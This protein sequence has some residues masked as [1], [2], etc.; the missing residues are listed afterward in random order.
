MRGRTADVADEPGVGD[1][2]LG[3][4]G[5]SGVVGGCAGRLAPVEVGHDRVVAKLGE[6]SDDLLGAAVVAGHVVD[7][8]NPA[9][10]PVARRTYDVGLDL[11]AVV[12][13]DPD[14]FCTH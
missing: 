1:S 3:A 7:H 9:A 13:S 10:W 12:S 2:T 14:G 8:D 4:G 11:L 6:P 5:G